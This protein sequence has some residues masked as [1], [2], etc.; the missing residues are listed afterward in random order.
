MQLCSV[1]HACCMQHALTC[2]CKSSLL[3]LRTR[4]LL[5]CSLPTDAT[6]AC[7]CVQL[8][9]NLARSSTN[10]KQVTSLVTSGS[11]RINQIMAQV[12]NQPGAAR[13]GF[14]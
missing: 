10:N 3:G 12:A 13:P 1:L 6:P 5:A 11:E 4:G 9:V 8:A 7:A 14:A 2:L